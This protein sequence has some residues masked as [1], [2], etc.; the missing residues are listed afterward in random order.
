M[1][2]IKLTLALTTNYKSLFVKRSIPLCILLFLFISCEE[3][4]EDGQPV[5][6][7][8]KASTLTGSQLAKIHCSRCHAFVDPNLI[9]KSIWKNLVLP[10]MGNRL[11]IYSEDKPR[12][13]LFR[14]GTEGEI[15]RQ[16]FIYP[17]HP[18]LAKEDWGK[19][20]GYYLE[21]A[22]DSL[23]P[24][25]RSTKINMDLPNF[26]YKETSYS[27]QPPLTVMVK[28]LPENKGIVFSDVK[29]NFNRLIFLS[30]ELKK[31]YDLRFRKVPIHYYEKSDTVFLT[32]IGENIFPNDGPHGIVQKLFSKKSGEK[33]D[34]LKAIIG[35]LQRPVSMAYG[36][37][38]NDGLEDMVA[39]EF[40]NY[41]GKLVWFE[42]KGNDKYSINTLNNNP[43]AIRAII[44]DVDE[45]GHMD[46]LALMSQGDEGIFL[47]KNNGN[48]K[49]TEK[50]LLT[51]LPL[52]GS[53]YM[54]LLDFNKD[55]FDDI[56]YVCGDNADK[57][58]Y[59]KSYHGIYVY[60]NDGDFNFKQSYFYQLNGAYKAMARD[61][62]L[63]GDLDIAAISFFPDYENSPEESFVYLENRGDFEFI[64]YSFPEAINGRWI[65]MDAV[66]MDADGDIDIALGS[67]VL[68][69]PK[70]DTTG[71]KKKWLSKGPSIIV[72][73]NT[74]R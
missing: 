2:I 43:G 10:F 62:D 3:K 31:K 56:I 1:D 36:D 6:E 66:D 21:N 59:L 22:P 26:S 48:G 8:I 39:C 53:Q 27:S 54:E 28:I 57:T 64:D 42:N 19:I 63:D 14:S 34:T 71:L 46:I 47:Y 72:L 55:G 40:G 5:V 16:A 74:I 67:H 13:S 32:T 7:E 37:L 50:R 70:G 69:G 73:E 11:G 61:Y 35:K 49:F 58:P 65:V 24:P 15:V 29:R 20:V 38:N 23:L 45:D 51:F 52:Y 41:T 18:I 9:T 25:K 12:D 4:K 17:E 44:R 30:P 68:F 60:L 33:Y